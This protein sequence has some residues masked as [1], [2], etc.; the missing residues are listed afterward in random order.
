MGP[1]KQWYKKRVRPVP[2]TGILS[3]SHFPPENNGNFL[4]CNAI[5][6]L[7][8]L[9]HKV[10][11]DGADINAVEIEPILVSSDPNFRPTDLEVGGDGAL[12][13]SDW[14]NPLIGHMQHNM[15]DPN[16]DDR[17]G[18]VY[19]V[20][21]TGRPLLKPAKM[22]GKPIADV[23][24]NFYAKENGTRYRARLELSGRPS[25]DVTAAVEKWAAGIKPDSPAN[26]QA[27]LEGLWV[28]QEHRVPNEALLAK[29]FQAK[30]PRVRAAAIRTMGDWGMRIKNWESL[31]LSAARD[32]EP[33]VR[34][35]AAKAAVSFEGLSAAEAV[36]EVAA[37]PTDVQLD[38]VLR[39]AQGKINVDKVVQDSLKSGR[40]L[41]LA[42]QQ[43]VLRNASID[44][45]LKLEPS[46]AV[47]RTILT[48]KNVPNQRLRD[49]LASL[50]KLRNES[51]FKLLLNLITELDA[52]EQGSSLAG[53][54]DL[55]LDQPPA[56]L[57][58]VQGP[59]KKLATGGNEA[60]T[61][62]LGY[63]GWITAQGSADDAL[64]FAS[65]SKAKLRDML[66]SLA[67]V[68]NEEV[69][70]AVF[71][72]VRALMFDLPAGLKSSGSASLAQPGIKVD[73]FEPN[74]K[75]VKLETLAKLKPRASGIVPEI[76][77]N[78]P[79]RKRPDA[80]A[81]RFTGVVRIDQPGDYTFFTKSDDGSRLYIDG[82]QVVDNDGLHGMTEN[83][84]AIQ[85]TAGW[86]PIVV[87]YFDNGGGDGLEVTWRGP[88]I[89]KKSRIPTDRLAAAAAD[90]LHDL[91]IGTLKHIP[92]YETEKFN[93]LF[94]LIKSNQNRTSAIRALTNIPEKHWPP[95]LIRPMVDNLVGHASRIPAKLRTGKEAQQAIGLARA[96]AAKLPEQQRQDALNR[97]QNLDV[98][99][100]AVGTVPHRMIYDKEQIAIQAGKPVEFRFSN[101][102][103]M[104]HN[105]AITLPGAM[106]EVGTLAENTA[107]DSD[108]MERQ[109]IPKS[110]KILL[111]SNLLQP[112]ETQAVTFD[113]PKQPG[114]Y[115][116]V[117]TYPGHWRRMYGA[118][119]VVAD[120]DAYEADPDGYLAAN[121]LEIKDELL[122]YTGTSH[123]WK[124]AELADGVK[125][126]AG[127]RNFE[128]GKQVFKVASCVSC[129]RL[130]KEGQ[131]FGPD[132]A[133]LDSAKKGPDHILRSILE[134][135]HEIEEKYYSNTFQLDS[136][137]VITGMVVEEND[138]MVK[139][140]QNPL[141]KAEAIVIPKNTIEERVKAKKSIMPEG[142]ANKLSREEILDLIAY[143][144]AKGD[145]KNKLFESHDHH[146]PK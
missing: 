121:K 125:P 116:Y 65:N 107:R 63:A 56:E 120:V 119:F 47:Y 27:L 57:Q 42:A 85:L 109:Y 10:E 5:G 146:H 118:L 144:F 9:Q 71:P 96:L 36:F 13:V 15:R 48:R 30:E 97:L 7:G 59:L 75:D 69:R 98:R 25:S 37:R 17:H 123:E 111:A 40:K 114:V 60:E 43:Y 145:K 1:P 31:L 2:A 86:H 83:R 117:C 3:S 64:L 4:I 129:H 22:K 26:E 124:L 108:A 67:L 139:V 137:M 14:C 99:V 103:S 135:S 8:V 16:R 100:I 112:G 6:F 88:G 32:D 62:R 106:E 41:S 90:N 95:K 55:L 132:L 82:K 142:L 35:E 140:I 50:A 39:Y 73:Y 11:Y 33:L 87:T 133:K 58:K 66:E 141:A 61:R 76:T 68:S 130:N 78:V 54:S 21:S 102:D 49:A 110:D 113:A 105:F 24:S 51:Q 23:L 72:K 143:V 115:P 79:Q 44:D 29:V 93:D 104:P 46:E 89:K 52:N 38:F 84:G 94:T 128:V 91:A 80:F 136:G 134:P 131:Q 77:M 101:T 45:L 19:R 74:P 34:A 138:Q 70:S 20:T 92:G 12:Y 122:A 126:L 53:V 18:R 28:F 81:L 127:G